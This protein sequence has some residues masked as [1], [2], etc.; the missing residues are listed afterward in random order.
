MEVVHPRCCGIDVHQARL[1]VCVSIK[2]TRKTEKYQL[3]CGT[4]TADLLRLAEWLHGHEVTHVAMEA[5]G[6]VL[7]TGVAH[8]GR[9]I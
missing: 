7:E 4:I 2:E 9:A 8:P 6:G 5:T 3:S 1:A